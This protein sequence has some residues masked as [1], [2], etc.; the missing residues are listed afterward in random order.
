LYWFE[1][2]VLATFFTPEVDEF[3]SRRIR[4]GRVSMII[5]IWLVCLW[6]R[7]PWSVRSRAF[8]NSIAY[9][10]RFI[11]YLNICLEWTQK[12]LEGHLQIA[13]VQ[14]VADGGPH[15]SVNEE[16]DLLIAGPRVSDEEILAWVKDVD[17]RPD[18]VFH[19]SILSQSGGIWIH[20]IAEGS[21]DALPLGI[22]TETDCNTIKASTP[23]EDVRLNPVLPLTWLSPDV[24]GSNLDHSEAPADGEPEKSSE[25][26]DRPPTLEKTKR[27][28]NRPSQKQRHREGKRARLAR[29]KELDKTLSESPVE[30]SSL[31]AAFLSVS[32]GSTPL[33]ALAPVFVPEQLVGEPQSGPLSSTP[34]PAQADTNLPKD[35]GSTSQ[36]YDGSSRRYKRRPR[37][38]VKPRVWM[39]G[40]CTCI[41]VRGCCL[42]S[43]ECLPPFPEAG[44]YFLMVPQHLRLLIYNALYGCSKG[45][46]CGGGC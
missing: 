42:G 46:S 45:F 28:R 29:E 40:G 1:E 13:L 7:I 43:L 3:P 39:D 35:G 5:K 18:S 44:G 14:F 2:G 31:S 8:S 41:C 10:R 19:V 22:A 20:R 36:D 17:S 33:S 34:V 21:T 23:T 32:A 4:L 37:R 24:D 26:E 27:R 30:A 11:F 12:Y 6:W 16:V 15:L 38:S 25:A 9:L